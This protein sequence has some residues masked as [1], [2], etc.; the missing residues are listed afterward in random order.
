MNEVRLNGDWENW[1]A[2][3][4]DAITYTANTAVDTS[5][6]LTQMSQ[7]DRQMLQKQ[8][9]FSITLIK[10]HQGLLQKPI[11]TA[12]YLEQCTKLAPATI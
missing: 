12:A 7:K 4:A 3:F 8:G 1:P 11:T 6:Q 10:L 2:F 9:R 5:R